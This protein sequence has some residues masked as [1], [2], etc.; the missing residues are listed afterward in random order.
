MGMKLNVGGALSGAASGATIG[1]AVPGIGTAIGAIGGGIMGLLSG[2]DNSNETMQQQLQN[3]KEL[4]GLQ[5]QYNT[6]MAEGNQQRAKEMWDYT[7]FENQRK[8]LEN[9]GLSVGLM[10]GNGGAGGASTSGGQGQGVGNPGTTAVQQGLQAK[11]LGVQMNNIQSQTALNTAQAAKAMSEAEKTKGVDTEEK[12]ASIENIIQQTENEKAKNGLIYAQQR[13]ADEEAELKSANV[14][15]INWNIKQITKSLDIMDNNLRIS[16]VE[17]E[18]A[19]ST[20]EQRIEQASLNVMESIKNILLKDKQANLTEEEAKAITAQLAQGWA[21]LALQK[22]GQELQR[23]IA[24]WTNEREYRLGWARIENQRK[25]S[26]AGAATLWGETLKKNIK[27][28][29]K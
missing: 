12:K 29:F 21:G 9:A 2:R 5:N 14:E 18:I 22:G 3:E 19:E 15:E 11:M 1:S 25:S 28:L 24:Q 17:A 13:L 10:Y 16:G 8:H 26:V 6:Q 23:T 27:N 4:M 20:K 7:N